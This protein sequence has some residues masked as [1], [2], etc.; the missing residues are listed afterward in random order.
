MEL[1]SDRFQSFSISA[2]AFK[3]WDILKV[4]VIRIGSYLRSYEKE[5]NM[6]PEEFI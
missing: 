6:M 2:L 5:F 3:S 4:G 1:F